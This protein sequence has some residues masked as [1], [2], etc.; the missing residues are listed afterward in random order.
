MHR[1]R[2]LVGE[3]HHL[4]RAYELARVFL[5]V[6]QPSAARDELRAL[7]KKEALRGADHDLLQLL[8][9]VSAKE[10]VASDWVNLAMYVIRQT[11]ERGSDDRDIA[12]RVCRDAAQLAS[13]QGGRSTHVCR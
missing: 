7:A 4:S 13:R 8:E 5:R 11:R 1:L 6:S 2:E 9:K 12:L 10:A 3:D